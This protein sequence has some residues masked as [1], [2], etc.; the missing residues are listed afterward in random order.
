MVIEMDQ[1]DDRDRRILR[2]LQQDADLSTQELADRV[3]L[4]SASCWRRIR[5]MQETGIIGP[6]VRLVDPARVGLGLDV[7]C[8]IRMKGQNRDMR[9]PFERFIEM[10]EDVVGCYSVSGEW[11][12]LLHIVTQDVA[13]YERVLMQ[14]ILEHEGIASSSSIFVLR[15]IKHTTAIPV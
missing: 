3:G 10:Q 13:V 1:L 2:V 6:S 8:Y 5:A 14:R 7:F 4:S 15:R 11:D 9:A 12:Y